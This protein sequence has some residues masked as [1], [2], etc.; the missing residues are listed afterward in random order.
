MS[1]VGKSDG[2]T[3]QIGS[4]LIFNICSLVYCNL[5]RFMLL[6]DCCFSIVSAVVGS[7]VNEMGECIASVG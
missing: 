7:D 5:F 2:F 1:S 6:P 3:L 4:S